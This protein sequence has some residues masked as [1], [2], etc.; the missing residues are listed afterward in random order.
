MRRCVRFTAAT[1]ALSLAVAGVGVAGASASPRTQASW[2][3]VDQVFAHSG[4]T[5]DSFTAVTAQ[6]PSS[7][8][9]FEST[10]S[11]TA[12]IVA[13]RLAGS[14]WSKIAFPETDGSTV[15]AA[16][17]ATPSSVYVATSR[18][19]LLTWTGVTWT[20]V[21][22]FVAINDIAATGAGDV[23]VTGRRTTSAASGGLWHLYRGTWRRAS[24]HFYGAIDAASDTAI[25]SV[26]DR[27]IEDF[28]GVSW[29]ITSLAAF[30]PPK[31]PLCQVPGLTSVDAM[32]PTDVWVTAA[33]NCQDFSGP[34]RL[35]HFVHSRWFI[36][37]N[38]QVA[39]GAAYSG[40]DGSLW[41]PTKAFACIGCTAM[42]HLE[43][44]RLTQVPLP[45]NN[46]TISD[47]ATAPG[48]KASIA[49]G[50]TLNG[51]DAQNMRGVILRYGT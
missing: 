27:A 17:G 32:T 19:A 33:G 40:G 36:A 30:L 44:G 49:V 11:K 18:G 34:F 23:W 46:Q 41:I 37:A 21:S 8:W 35:L 3:V 48:S 38:R 14:T 9:A 16:T 4:P 20:L 10:A 7:A 50:W 24:I 25:F 26:T 5:P 2:H 47:I 15:S 43:A 51:T 13:W 12:P 31:Q 1:A 42:L 29:H 28:N 39:R 6:T 45:L 22:K